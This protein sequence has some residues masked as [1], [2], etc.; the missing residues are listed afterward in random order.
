MPHRRLGVAGVVAGCPTAGAREAGASPFAR[1]LPVPPFPPNLEWVNAGPV[2]L[3]RLRGH[4]ILLDFW[5]LGCINCMH[6]IPELK[7]LE[8][9]WP[10]ELV[11]IGVHSAKF[12][13]ERDIKNIQAAALRYGIA[14]P[15]VNDARFTIWNSFGIQAWPSLVLIDPEGYAVWGHSGEITFAEARRPAPPRGPVL[16]AQGLARRRVRATGA[17]A[18]RGGR[19]V[20]PPFSGQNPGR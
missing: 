3:G 12:E 1:R 14:H 18:R 17:E 2:D 5:T 13:S 20:G 15:I 7:K 16:S 6:L 9:A 8:K 19:E 10:D 4:F 11:V